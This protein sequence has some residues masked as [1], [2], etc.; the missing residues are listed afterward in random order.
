MKVVKV[1]PVIT[2]VQY[3]GVLRLGRKLATNRV[4]ITHFGEALNEL[5]RL[6][7]LI[8]DPLS[9]ELLVRANDTSGL[10]DVKNPQSSTGSAKNE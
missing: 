1:R 8:T 3:Y 2:E 4:D 7:E 5:L 10:I 6:A 9:Q